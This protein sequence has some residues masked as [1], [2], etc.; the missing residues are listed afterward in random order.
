M[1]RARWVRIVIGAAVGMVTALGLGAPLGTP[2]AAADAEASSLDLTAR[3]AVDVHLG[4]KSRAVAVETVITLEN[5]THDPAPRLVLNTLAAAVGRM[6]LRSVTVGD[7]VVEPVVRGQ[8]I[9]LP[10]SPALSPGGQVTVRV[11]YRATLND[12]GG[13]YRWMFCRTRGIADLYRFI[14]WLSREVE[15]RG[16]EQG[17]PFVT[18]VSP[19]V[20][21]NLTS[22]RPLTYATSG[23]RVSI[24][25]LT[26][27]FVARDVRDFNV[28]ASPGYRVLTGWSTDGETRIRALTPGDDGALLLRA[29]RRALAAFE[30]WV[31]EYP[32]PT[33]DVAL[34]GAGYA[35]ESPSLVWIPM[36]LHR[37]VASFVVHEVAHQWFYGVV[38]SDQAAEPFA[39]EAVTEFL[40]LTLT[41]GFGSSDCAKS[42]L[43]GSVY[44]YG[45]R[46]YDDVI[47][48]QGANF[49]EALRRDFDDAAFWA[50]LAIYY[51]DERFELST[52]R[53]LLE[54]FRARLGD[55][56]LPR[57]RARFPSLY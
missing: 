29:A 11:D 47:Y 42:R 12:T 41:G 19:F 4:W 3:Y 37:D 6:Q 52:N 38:G 23:S 21:V 46:C 10:L 13:G 55:R 26:Q 36:T 49:L 43:D 57:F 34:S 35:M 5:P 51:R 54:A 22:D 50:A 20:R 33:L 2:M 14:P 24:R 9:I 40:T 56:V 18:P 8:T 7:R 30:A 53:R 16:A 39:D 32:Y 15:L 44:A 28:S 48:V 1:T 25:G 17:D 27:T 45:S 31:G